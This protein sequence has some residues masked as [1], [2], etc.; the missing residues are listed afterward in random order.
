M[1]AR[2]GQHEQLQLRARD[3]LLP[4]MRSTVL[5]CACRSC[6]DSSALPTEEISAVATDD[7]EPRRTSVSGST[8]LT[9]CVSLPKHAR[10]YLSGFLPYQPEE[11]V[12]PQPRA[13]SPPP[14]RGLLIALTAKEIRRSRGDGEGN[15]EIARRRRR[16]Y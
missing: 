10:Q 14:G 1:C 2:G 5:T 3:H 16:D 11:T 8:C 7:G 13:H 9:R 12:A 15:Q 6:H 4:R